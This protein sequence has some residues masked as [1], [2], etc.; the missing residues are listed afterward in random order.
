MISAFPKV[1]DN[2]DIMEELVTAWEDYAV[3]DIK[4]RKM[5][6]D[7]VFIMNKTCDF[8]KRLYPV[9]YSSDFSNMKSMGVTKSGDGLKAKLGTKRRQLVRNALRFNQA[10]IK[11][12]KNDASNPYE[13]T[14]FEP[15]NINELNYEVWDT[16]KSTA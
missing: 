9:L 10:A 3:A 12:K 11:G 16:K 4:A 5:E 15:F 1:L 6:L 2:P 14:S 7:C 8:V 13:E